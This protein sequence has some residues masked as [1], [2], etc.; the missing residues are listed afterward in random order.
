MTRG[1]RLRAAGLVLGLVMAAGYLVAV[2]A[3]MQLSDAGVIGF[4]SHDP[5]LH[6]LDRNGGVGILVS[7]GGL[8]LAVRSAYPGFV[9]VPLLVLGL[10][11]LLLIW[12]YVFG[13]AFG[14]YVGRPL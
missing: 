10:P 3:G 14:S 7:L 13:L 2:V 6:A 5:V 12:L 9:W 11:L 4:G 1:T 8:A